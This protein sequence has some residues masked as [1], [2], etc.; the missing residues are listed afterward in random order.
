MAF[1]F[2]YTWCPEE[3]P[4]GSLDRETAGDASGLFQQYKKNMKQC[5]DDKS[6]APHMNK[7]SITD[8]TGKVMESY[9]SKCICTYPY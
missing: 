3:M 1:K 7:I 6:L 8:E 4:D 5:N 2:N 9:E